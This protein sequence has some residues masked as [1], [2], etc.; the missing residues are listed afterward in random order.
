[1]YLMLS[2]GRKSV[3]GGGELPTHILLIHINP[4]G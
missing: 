4:G 2:G 1:M 3:T